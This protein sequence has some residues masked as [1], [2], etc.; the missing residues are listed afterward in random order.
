MRGSARLYIVVVVLMM[1]VLLMP[2]S[3]MGDALQRHIL[4]TCINL[5]WV[6][7]VL[8]YE[9]RTTDN[10]AYLSGCMNNAA[11]H[12]YAVWENLRAPHVGVD[13]SG[14]YD[15]I[16]DWNGNTA[17]WYGDQVANYYVNPIYTS[18]VDLWGATC[19]RTFAEIG[20]LFGRANIAAISGD[21][22]LR[23]Y[24]LYWM[25]QNVQSG[26]AQAS[27]TGCSFGD[28]A[29]WDSLQV[30]SGDL[31]AASFAT[32]RGQLQA[33]A[34][35]T[36]TSPDASLWD[37]RWVSTTFGEMT[38]QVTGSTFTGTFG[39]DNGRIWGTVVGRTIEGYWVTDSEPQGGTLRLTVNDD[40]RSFSGTRYHAVDP[41]RVD[42]WA[43][44]RWWL[45]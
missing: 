17:G 3:S 18:F 28:A 43:G 38:V 23:D 35:G 42:N 26:L 41:S 14:I 21:T 2:V 25:K 24:L 37:G 20:Y 1:C 13:V 31:T 16:Y 45:P 32:T 10:I 36:L 9:G 30:F 11:A 7:G 34:S 6:E 5:G 15:R 39:G 33:I 40:D 44:I 4:D 22:S 29:A 12:V 27:S 19:E 8:L